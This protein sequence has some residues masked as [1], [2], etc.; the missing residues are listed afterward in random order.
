M[1]SRAGEMTQQGGCLTRDLS[2]VSRVRRKMEAENLFHGTVMCVLGYVHS[3][4]ACAHM[5]NNKIRR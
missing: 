2:S 5:Y 1:H 3:H 4:K